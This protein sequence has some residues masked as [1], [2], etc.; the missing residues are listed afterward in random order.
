MQ[1]R[2]ESNIIERY[3]EHKPVGRYIINTHAIHN[4]HLVRAALPRSLTMPLPL[5]LNRKEEHVKIASAYRNTQGAKRETNKQKNEERK[6]KREEEK[7]SEAGTQ[8]AKKKRTTAV[9]GTNRGVE[10]TVNNPGGI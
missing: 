6:R 9:I 1:E 7:G 3:I 2:V 8:R 10:G 4:A 5:F